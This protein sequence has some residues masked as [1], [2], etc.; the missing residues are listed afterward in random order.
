MPPEV[1][2]QW[3]NCGV[4]VRG[5]YPHRGKTTWAPSCHSHCQLLVVERGALAGVGATKSFELE[6]NDSLLLGP[7]MHIRYELP[8]RG[9]VLQV[10][11]SPLHGAG[12]HPPWLAL[13]LP[14]L[15]RG[16]DFSALHP[17][18]PRMGKDRWFSEDD[19]IEAR[20][21]MDRLLWSIGKWAH[22]D[23]ERIC[24]VSR[25]P[26]LREA[27]EAAVHLIHDSKFN[28]GSLARLAGCSVHHLNRVLKETDGMTARDF[29]RDQRI[30]RAKHL[31]DHNPS[32]SSD[33]IAGRCG[34]TSG[35]HFWDQW[36]VAT[37]QGLQAYRKS[38]AK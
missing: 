37:G 24:K 25:P 18:V 6:S 32:M 20:F 33:T 17:L 10:L 16:V 3:M 15:I 4:V 22:A 23:P 14:L 29:L 13:K 27:I 26:W 12:H 36:K 35:R 8:P 7:D 28:V 30:V 9:R 21:V 11:F 1:I 5:I 38:L 2:S 34:F 31:V 19:A